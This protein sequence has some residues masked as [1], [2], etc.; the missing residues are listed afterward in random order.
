MGEAA[1]GE[2][3]IVNQRQEW[4]GIRIM[5]KRSWFSKKVKRG[6]ESYKRKQLRKS[7]KQKGR[8]G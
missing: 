4:M 7:G 3:L 6:V 8:D 1:R 5:S 2:Q